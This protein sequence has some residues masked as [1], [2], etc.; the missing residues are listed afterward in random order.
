ME[1]GRVMPGTPYFHQLSESRNRRQQA[2]AQ[3]LPFRCAKMRK[4]KNEID[5]TMGCAELVLPNS[6]FVEIRARD[7]VK[8]K[9]AYRLNIFQS[10]SA[11]FH[12]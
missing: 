9:R 1:N 7:T 4:E 12:L 5:S 3:P 8:S 11:L 10:I 2:S 6:N